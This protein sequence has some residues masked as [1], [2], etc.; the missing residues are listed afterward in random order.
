M[1][2]LAV[3]D[4]TGAGVTSATV[5]CATVGAG[6]G[7]VVLLN[8]VHAPSD[9]STNASVE[10]SRYLTIY[11]L[12]VASGN[13]ITNRLPVPGWLSTHVRPWWAWTMPWT[14]ASPR[15]APSAWEGAAR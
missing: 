10:E 13:S 5:G 11:P 6:A 15:P 3:G 2:G 8:D 14:M 1:E 7:G 4:A 12:T 9:R